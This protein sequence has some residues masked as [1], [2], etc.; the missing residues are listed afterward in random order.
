M[1]AKKILL[2]AFLCSCLALTSN[3]SAKDAPELE[4]EG[5]EVEVS[6]VIKNETASY[7]KDTTNYNNTGF[8]RL[9]HSH[10]AGDVMKFE[11]SLNLFMNAYVGESSVIHAQL[12]FIKDGHGVD[13][14]EHHRNYSQND[15]LRELYIDTTYGDW[16]F[17]I[18]K[19]QVVWGTADGV[20]FLDIINP[21]D[22]REWGQNTMEDSRIPLWMVTAETAV[23]DNGSLQVVWVV[24]PQINQIPGLHNPETGDKG[25]PF[26]SLGVNSITGD[27]NGFYNIGKEFG[28]V[29]SAFNGAFGG[30]FGVGYSANILAGFG[31][32]TVKDFTQVLDVSDFLDNAGANPTNILLPA[33]T[34]GYTINGFGQITDVGIAQDGPTGNQMLTGVVQNPTTN[35]PPTNG[36]D[37]QTNLY[38]GELSA[39]NQNDIFDFLQGTTFATFNDFQGMKTQYRKDH[40]NEGLKNHNLGLRY[41]SSTDEGTNF[42]FNYYYHWDNN[43]TVDLHWED[44]NGDKLKTD[45]YTETNQ[46][47]AG[48]K[49]VRLLN[50]NDTHFNPDVDGTTGAVTSGATL[51]FQE[52][53]HRVHSIGG[54]FDTTVDTD[55]AP[56]VIRGEFVYDKGAKQVVMDKGLLDIGDL[57][58]AMKSEDADTVKFVIGADV[59]VMTNLFVS[60]Q[61]MQLTNLD[62]VDETSAYGNSG[63]FKRYTANP[64]TMHITNGFAAAQEHQ[65]GFTLFLSKPFLENDALRVN[66]IFLYENEEAGIWNRFDLEYSYSD[67]I[68]LTAEYNYYGGDDNAVFGQFVEQTNAQVGFKYLF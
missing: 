58:G 23:G 22:F 66:N 11:N 4:D 6:G 48:Y 35:P 20:K 43:P 16:D 32:M 39:T 51:V 65:T 67:N 53:M 38:D 63:T 28:S 50:A 19:Q 47:P 24:D 2:S 60:L 13:G 59:T 41:K 34:G 55:F 29:S 9:G 26:T 27:Y 36:I 15:Y 1:K 54:S 42:S 10:E 7:M 46:N 18:G 49:S 57:A 5:I 44:A 8:N 62:Y 30:A 31:G 14:Y 21:T 33:S 56:V 25:Q 12:N 64:A 68:I 40:K 17:R 52:N 3:L 45:I 61:Y 37:A